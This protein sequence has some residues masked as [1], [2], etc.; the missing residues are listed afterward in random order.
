MH[1][2]LMHNDPLQQTP[3]PEIETLIA[4]DM[5]PV[6]KNLSSLFG[7]Y[8][9]A[10]FRIEEAGVSNHLEADKI[11]AETIPEPEIRAFILTNL[12][13]VKDQRT[14]RFRNNLP[15]IRS[16]LSSIWSFPY[17]EEE[18]QRHAS[19]LTYDRPSLFVAGQKAKYVTED[20]HPTIRRWFPKAEIVY[21][22]T[23]HW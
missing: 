9:Q 2:A 22:D 23:G 7:K 13:A 8:I 10:M 20:A 19:S 18:Q 17:A 12:K 6:T 1:L 14:M 16:S 5:A 11:L 4:V 3:I 21:L 15:A